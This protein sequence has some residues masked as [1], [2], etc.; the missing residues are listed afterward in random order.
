MFGVN[1]HGNKIC[2]QYSGLPKW[3]FGGCKRGFESRVKR[4]PTISPVRFENIWLPRLFWVNPFEVR[5][6]LR[7]HASQIIRH[8]G[9][10][11]AG[12]AYRI[13]YLLH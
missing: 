9:E 12:A 1:L 4:L 2:P 8:I 3:N 11:F 7:I 6:T 5:R 10:G 13:I